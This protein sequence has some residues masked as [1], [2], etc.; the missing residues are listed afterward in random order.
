M[1]LKD[2]LFVLR[3]FRKARQC[4]CKLLEAGTTLQEV[5]EALATIVAAAPILES[6]LPEFE[7]VTVSSSVETDK[8][9]K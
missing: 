1:K 7:V 8:I 9:P 3:L 4:R 5:D 2:A 6:A